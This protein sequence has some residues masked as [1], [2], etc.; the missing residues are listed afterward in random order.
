ML[1]YDYVIEVCEMAA[2]SMAK[3][4]EQEADPRLRAAMWED[5]AEEVAQARWW[6]DRDAARR[7]S[8]S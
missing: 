3:R 2:K 5:A 4:A 6:R 7:A 8:L 1:P